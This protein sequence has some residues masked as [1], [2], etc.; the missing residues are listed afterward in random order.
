M[1]D[2]EVHAQ[3]A[4]RYVR[5]AVKEVRAN[6]KYNG[7]YSKIGIFWTIDPF[8]TKARVLYCFYK[9]SETVAESLGC[10]P[11]IVASLV[12]QPSSSLRAK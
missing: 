3:Y 2:G 6:R 8:V 1:K 9:A 10:L 12:N 4:K 5:Q 11:C 7:E